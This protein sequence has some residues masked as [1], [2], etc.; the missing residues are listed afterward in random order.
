VSM[1]RTLLVT[2]GPMVKSGAD[3]VKA[4]GAASFR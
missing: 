2:L 4:K 1:L 3:R